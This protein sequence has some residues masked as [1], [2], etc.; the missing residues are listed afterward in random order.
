ML[1]TVLIVGLVNNNFK[2]DGQRIQVENWSKKEPVQKSR[3]GQKTAKSKKWIR[4]K[5]TEASKAKNLGQLDTSLIA[6]TRR[7]FTKL[8][9]MFIEALILNYFDPKRHIR[10]EMDALG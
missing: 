1:K 10:I 9:Q 6:D 4:A 7:A 8:R 3:K 2:Q 5:K